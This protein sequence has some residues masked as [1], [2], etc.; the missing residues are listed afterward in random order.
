MGSLTFFRIKPEY[1]NPDLIIADR[2]DSKLRCET[3]RVNGK[4]LGELYLKRTENA[5]PPWLKYFGESVDLTGI[6]LRTASLAALLLIKQD[7]A[8]YAVAF[9]YGASLLAEGVAEERFGLRATLN[10]VE[11]SQLRSIDHKRL[12][13]ISRH[14]REQLSRAGGLAQFGLDVIRELLRAVTG[15]PADAKYGKRLSGSDQLTVSADIPLTSLKTALTRYYELSEATTYAKNFPW[16]DNIQAIHNPVLARAL[17]KQLA[18]VLAEGSDK[19]WLAPP[20]IIDWDKTEGFKYRD[21]KKRDPEIDL[22]LARYFEECGGADGLLDGARL[23]QD[24]IFH[25]RSD[26][27]TTRH[28][29]S[30]IRCLVGELEY[31]SEHYILNEGSWYRVNSD[32]LGAL[33]GF[34]SSV[35][36]TNIDLP[37]YDDADEG[38]YNKRAWQRDKAHL[39]LLDQA[40]I[41]YPNRGKVEVCDLYSKKKQFVH[42]KR[43]SCS[44]T[45]SH[46]FSQGTVSA[47]LL[48]DE[49]GFRTKFLQKIPAFQW[50]SA[51]DAIQPNDFEVCYAIICR[52]NKPLEI[53][54]FSKLSLRNAFQHLERLGFRCSMIGIPS[55]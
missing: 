34:I 55:K 23:R 27:D 9:G 6:P 24:R 52:K 8:F 25:I 15:A 43:L 5:K 48:R 28:S 3:V 10:A 11:P 7:D 29:W 4:R 20:E 38:A 37:D 41:Q 13:A 42:V 21:S 51:A 40:F 33:H 22:D 19:F 32:F 2:D 39:A 18:K 31:D 54:F 49:A 14:T 45:L 17:E 50:G 36:P 16:V 26:T 35:K 46:L 53:P 44:S 47:E 30:V 1:N 12:E